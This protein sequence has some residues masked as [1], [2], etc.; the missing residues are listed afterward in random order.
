MVKVYHPDTIVYFV[1]DF[2]N[3]VQV[4]LLRALSDWL[5]RFFF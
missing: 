2:V 1:I 4:N 5:G 3:P